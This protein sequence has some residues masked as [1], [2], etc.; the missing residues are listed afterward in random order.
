MSKQARAERTRDAIVRGAAEA[1][2]RHGFVGA[3]LNDMVNYA[4]VT[5]GALYFHFHSKE[6]LA[7]AV[8][9]RQHEMSIGQARESLQRDAPGLTSAILLTQSMVRQ[10]IE[11]PI[12]RAGVRLTLESGAFLNPSP[13]PYADWIDATEK[14]LERAAAE[15]DIQLPLNARDL[16]WHITGS[17]IGVQLMSRALTAREDL[18]Q[19]IREMWELLLPALV[20]AHQLESYRSVLM[21]GVE[22][23]G[24]P[25]E[26]SL[27]A[28]H[29]H[30][31]AS[32]PPGARRS[33][34]PSS[35]PVIAV[36]PRATSTRMVKPSSLIT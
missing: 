3:T 9:E 25:Y 8:I 12:A 21:N 1:F 6:E 30:R 31:P 26:V 32:S 18:R 35:G 28:D 17:F 5:K 20:P 4:D 34:D 33:R 19:R 29:D 27:P 15:G 14:L 7:R 11:D 2:D 13:N 16:A 23:G 36:V 22:P 10:L 24:R